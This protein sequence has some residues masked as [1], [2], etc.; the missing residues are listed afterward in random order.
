MG[1][2]ERPH[3]PSSDPATQLSYEMVELRRRGKLTLSKLAKRTNYT[4]SALSRATNAKETSSWKVTIAYIRE[5][6][7]ELGIV[8]NEKRWKMLWEAANSRKSARRR[9]PPTRGAANG[10]T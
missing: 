6:E 7:L 4:A 3:E 8:T 9:R 5:C 1:W 2:P 10:P